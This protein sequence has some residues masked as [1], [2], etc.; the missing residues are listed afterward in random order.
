VKR[1]LGTSIAALTLI[2]ASLGAAGA[3]IELRFE[4][5]D[6]IVGKLL[7]LRLIHLETGVELQRIAAPELSISNFDVTFEGLEPGESYRVDVYGDVNRSGAYDAPPADHA[8][9]L[10]FPE[11][12]ESES[13]TFVHNTDFTDIDWPPEID[14][15]LAPGDYRNVLVDPATGLEVSWQ[16]D[17]ETIYVGLSAEVAGYVAIGFAPERRMEGANILIAAVSDG[18]LLIEDHFG[19]S[20]TGH[21][22]DVAS[23]VIQAAGT[24]EDGRTTVEFAYPLDTGAEDDKPLLP[25]SDVVIILA[26]HS[27]SDSLATRHTSRSTTTITLDE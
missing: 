1:I 18:E 22:K 9:R 23:N 26:V 19:T 27:S 14:G 20:Q 7:E 13:L 5:M 12:S 11:I 17:G 15:V 8:W 4:T 2:A 10:E 24:E 6:P 21:S 16:N 25:G 3:S